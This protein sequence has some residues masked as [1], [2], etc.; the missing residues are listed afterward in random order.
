MIFRSRLMLESYLLAED[1]D[2]E[3][4]ATLRRPA[5]S[6]RYGDRN[7]AERALVGLVAQVS[8]SPTSPTFGTV[9]E[10]CDK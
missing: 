2:R 9:G 4:G 1:K 10:L 8:D 5:D 7:A 3:D 6:S